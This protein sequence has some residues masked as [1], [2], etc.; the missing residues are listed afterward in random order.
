MLDC[1]FN[2]QSVALVGATLNSEK[3]SGVI[4]ESLSSR[5][6]GVLYPVN[7]AHEELGGRKCYPSIRAI[8]EPLD[9]A[10][11]A[12]GAG[13]IPEMI[14]DAA[15]LIRGAV[16]VSG[17]FKETGAV[18]ARL[19]ERLRK[20]AL[21]HGIRI[22]GP[23][24]LGIYDTVTGLDTFFIPPKRMERP[25]GG[26]LSILSQSGS[27]AVTVMD[28]LAAEGTGVARVISY[29]NKADVNESDCLDFLAVDE[30]TSAVVLY[31]ESVEEGRRFVNAA[32]RCVLNKPVAALKVGH[33][34]PA[35]AAARSHTGA[36]AGKYEIYSAAF[37][38][39]GIIELQGYE[40]FLLACRVLGENK[41]SSRG[42]RVMVITDGGGIG[43]AI[44]DE[45][46]DLG[47]EVVPLGDSVARE[48]RRTLPPVCSISNPMDLTGSVTDRDF[49]EALLKTLGGDGFDMAIVAS[50]WGPPGLTDNLPALIANQK[51][52]HKKPVIIC[53]P[54]GT[55]TRERTGLFRSQELPVFSTPESAA[56]AAS[57][58]AE[59]G[60]H[61]WS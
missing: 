23:N 5:F 51:K 56:R 34:A 25:P 60:R 27:F 50:L 41:E 13:H 7:P 55:Y 38:K 31:I 36:M 42:R 53:T 46:A 18:G 49:G 29:G 22:I 11:F 3:L 35:A 44:A 59:G 45:C 57:F 47:L 17:G 1:F 2:P 20:S 28:E 32:S 12:I 19:E 54:G 16:I 30:A 52:Y 26:G 61:R 33:T 9:L 40:D 8:N 39:A 10:V 4:Y 24:C 48:L 6:S 58:L 14:E 43:V 37:R 21:K 15:G